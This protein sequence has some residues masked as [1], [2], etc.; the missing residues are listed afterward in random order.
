R[1]LPHAIDAALALAAN[2][3]ATSGTAIACAEAAGR[4]LGV[5]AAAS[6]A[7]IQQTL[8]MITSG[9]LWTVAA[10]LEPSDDRPDAPVEQVS[11]Y[12][13]ACAGVGEIVGARR[14]A[15]RLRARD[16]LLASAGMAWPLVAMASAEVAWFT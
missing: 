10:L 7:R 8:S 3:P 6:T 1:W 2:D 4:R 13:L 5:S 12:G 15:A 14:A 16:C 11:V 9:T